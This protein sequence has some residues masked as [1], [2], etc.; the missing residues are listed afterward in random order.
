MPRAG[1]TAEAVVASA[2]TMLDEAPTS[3]LSLSRIASE[4]GVRT[5]SLYNHVA[6]LDDL[7]RRVAMGGI[8]ALGEALRT[9]VMGKSGPDALRAVAA[10]YRAYAVAHPG[11]Y[12]LTQEARPDDDE[13]AALG[14]RTIEPAEAALRS[15]GVAEDELI[16]RVRA[17]RSALHGF[18][19]LET[20]HGFGIDVDIDASFETLVQVL[21]TSCGASG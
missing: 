16:H 6:G 3:E 12:P 4:L 18:V 2:A 10:A 13:Y 21:T 19:L 8:V 15:C 20:Q 14:L 7:R 17:L 9:A 5:P 1:L 11:I